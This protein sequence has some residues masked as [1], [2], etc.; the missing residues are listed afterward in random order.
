MHRVI[1]R[2]LTSALVLPL[3]IAAPAMAG[4]PTDQ[5]KTSI[6]QV[7]KVV[8][9]PALKAEGN[10]ARRRA[11]VREVA[12][13]TFDFGEAAKRALGRHWQGLAEKDRQEFTG[14]FADLL[15]RGYVSRIEE[16][17]GEKI[18]YAGE[19]MEGDTATVKTRFTTKKG[20]EIPV[21][22][23]M[24]KKGDKWLVYDVN[25]EGLS[26]VGNYRGQFNKIIE[27]S[28]YQDLVKRMKARADE[29]QGPPSTKRKES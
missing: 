29:F 28:S 15:E 13:N 19:S 10:A 11:A 17:S 1:H 7:I 14:L 6:E 12:N 8:E 22:Y 18:V 25:V 16:Y 5:L 23:R 21:D 2:A 20:T 9:D 4:A 24:L 26:L 3:L 27:T